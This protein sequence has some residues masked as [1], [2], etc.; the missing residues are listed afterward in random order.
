VKQIDLRQVN[1]P[2]KAELFDS[3]PVN[4]SISE[5]AASHRSRHDSP[6]NDE[7]DQPPKPPVRRSKKMVKSTINEEDESGAPPHVF[8]RQQPVGTKKYGN[9]SIKFDKNT[10]NKLE[11][12]SSSANNKQLFTT[13]LNIQHQSSTQQQQPQQHLQQPPD[14]GVVFRSS[15]SN[16]STYYDNHSETS[17]DN[18]QSHDHNSSIRNAL[19]IDPVVQQDLHNHQQQ[20]AKSKQPQLR[21]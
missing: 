2:L 7:N 10:T 3:L 20:T 8:T 12:T 9:F 1:P 14:P 19:L 21:A 13:Q 4:N 11:S 5:Q 18:S 15:R 17:Y 16:S 6:K